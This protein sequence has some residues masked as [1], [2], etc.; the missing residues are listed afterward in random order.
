MRT[1]LKLFSPFWL[2]IWLLFATG[3]AWCRSRL[4]QH[5]QPLTPVVRRE[6]GGMA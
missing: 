6:F 3:M 1:A 4:P 2:L 5:P